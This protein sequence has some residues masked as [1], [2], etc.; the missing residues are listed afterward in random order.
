MLLLVLIRGNFTIFCETSFVSLV[1]FFIQIIKNTLDFPT[2][3]LFV[4]L[5]LFFGLFRAFVNLLGLLQIV[6]NDK[7]KGLRTWSLE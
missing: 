1:V 2:L 7:S 4:R 3:S 6:D 5:F